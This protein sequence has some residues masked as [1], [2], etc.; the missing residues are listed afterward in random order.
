[1]DLLH[2]P[3]EIL[4]KI[5]RLVLVYKDRIQINYRNDPSVKN[6]TPDVSSTLRICRQLH[7]LAVPILYSE[8]MFELGD[9]FT[10]TDLSVFLS[11][12]SDAGYN[13]ITQISIPAADR[14][15]DFQSMLHFLSGCQSLRILEVWCGSDIIL[16]SCLN[17]IRGFR[18]QQ[19]EFVL[20]AAS[21]EEILREISVL[22]CSQ[23]E[24]SHDQ[25]R[26]ATETREQKVVLPTLIA[27]RADF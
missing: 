12:L 2:L 20:C 7:E 25:K 4:L 11:T 17:I 21:Q 5:F 15:R 23:A 24:R 1:M 13:S 8:N 16:E 3:P 26:A 14:T 10:G 19:L 6:L 9:P 22:V 27:T 18:L